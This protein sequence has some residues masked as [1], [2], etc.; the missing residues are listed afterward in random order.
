MHYVRLK[1]NRDDHNGWYKY[2]EQYRLKKEHN[3]SL[4]WWTVDYELW[5]MFVSTQSGQA[6]SSSVTSV[7]DTYSGVNSSFRS[8]S[9]AKNK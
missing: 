4:Y 2:V 6:Q 5:I 9:G 3:P 1:A 8:N 7:Q